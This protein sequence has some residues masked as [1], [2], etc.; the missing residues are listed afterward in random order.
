MIP[1]LEVLKLNTGTYVLVCENFSDDAITKRVRIG[2]RL[3]ERFEIERV[4]ECFSAAKSRDIVLFTEA[5][6]SNVEKIEFV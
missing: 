2:D 5:N 1:V 3:F 4:R 6:L